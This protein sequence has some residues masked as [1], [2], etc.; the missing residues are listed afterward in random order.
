MRRE[1]R[2]EL[3]LCIVTQSHSQFLCVRRVPL[4]PCFFLLI[5]LSP[6]KARVCCSTHHPPTHALL[7]AAWRDF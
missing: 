4:L 5:A 2:G 3:P 6:L 1:R 7:L